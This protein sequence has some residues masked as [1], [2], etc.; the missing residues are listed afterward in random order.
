M[1]PDPG[2][3]H[4]ELTRF[5]LLRLGDFWDAKLRKDRRNGRSAKRIAAD[6]GLDIETVEAVAPARIRK[7]KP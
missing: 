1:D 7:R 6:Y 5:K 4:R 2:L 3:I